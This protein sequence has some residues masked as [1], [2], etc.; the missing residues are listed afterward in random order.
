VHTAASRRK[1]HKFQLAWIVDKRMPAR[2]CIWQLTKKAYL[3]DVCIIGYIRIAL[4]AQGLNWHYVACPP[5]SSGRALDTVTANAACPACKR[6]TRLNN[7]EAR[8]RRC[9]SFPTLL[10][11][12]ARKRTCTCATARCRNMLPQCCV[13]R[14]A[15]TAYYRVHTCPLALAN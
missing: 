6:S 13:A 5:P 10:T 2:H 8:C 3:H 4:P 1:T 15:R 7:V 11:G 9:S 14:R 12:T